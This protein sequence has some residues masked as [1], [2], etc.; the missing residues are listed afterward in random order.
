MQLIRDQEITSAEMDTNMEWKNNMV[1]FEDFS[2]F[3]NL[4][5]TLNSKIVGQM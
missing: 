2:L 3:R 5:E 1:R 4:T